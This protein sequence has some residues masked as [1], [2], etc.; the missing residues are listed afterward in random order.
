MVE[1]I[2][3]QRARGKLGK[4]RNDFVLKKQ[5][6]GF[7]KPTTDVN[8]QQ[9][10]DVLNKHGLIFIF[11]GVDDFTIEFR[12]VNIMKRIENDRDGQI[13]DEQDRMIADKFQQYRMNI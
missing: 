10:F 11:K 1:D 13:K 5:K 7:G 12:N 4:A 8:V 2:I 3:K 6:G 9:P